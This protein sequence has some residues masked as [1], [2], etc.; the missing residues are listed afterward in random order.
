MHNVTA[1]PLAQHLRAIIDAHGDAWGFQY[2]HHFGDLVSVSIP[3][4]LGRFTDERFGTTAGRNKPRHY[5]ELFLGMGLTFARA[6]KVQPERN[7][8]MAFAHYVIHAHVTRK[9]AALGVERSTYY[10]R[11]DT[12]RLALAPLILGADVAV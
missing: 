11:L 3:S 2:R 10:Q 12:L 1:D 9:A 6:L 4:I 8:E 7:V 5:P